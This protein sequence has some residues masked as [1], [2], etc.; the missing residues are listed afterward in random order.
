M[1]GYQQT[2]GCPVV[3]MRQTTA[4]SWQGAEVSDAAAEERALET[5]SGMRMPAGC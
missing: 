5:H 1:R 2:A 4:W 3:T